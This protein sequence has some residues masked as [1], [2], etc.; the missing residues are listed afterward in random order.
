MLQDRDVPRPGG[1]SRPWG[2]A[3]GSIDDR[4]PTLAG[5]PGALSRLDRWI[6]RRDL[7]RA[8]L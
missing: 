3:A 5:M 6:H 7:L 4:S 2:S 1:V 8:Q